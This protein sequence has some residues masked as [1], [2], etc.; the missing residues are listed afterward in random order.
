VLDVS[1]RARVVHDTGGGVEQPQSVVQFPVGQQP[2]V[3]RDLRA[4]EF[5]PQAAVETDFQAFTL[6]ST[7]PEPLRMSKYAA[8]I[9]PYSRP[10]QQI[11]TLKWG[12]RAK[13]TISTR[14][15]S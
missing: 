1:A 13:A 5:K 4:V 8:I 15:E 6:R 12:M 14:R 9:T 11:H 3:G 7:H 2:G 10:D